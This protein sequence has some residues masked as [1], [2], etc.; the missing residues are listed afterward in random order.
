MLRVVANV[1]ACQRT[2]STRPRVHAH[3]RHGGAQTS[4]RLRQLRSSRLRRSESTKKPSRCCQSITTGE[5]SL[6]NASTISSD[7]PTRTPYVIEKWMVGIEIRRDHL[8]GVIRADSHQAVAGVQRPG[9]PEGCEPAT[10]SPPSAAAGACAL[11]RLRLHFFTSERFQYI[12]RPV[13]IN[14]NGPRPRTT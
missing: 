6:K 2:N 13:T 9:K 10:M 5:S 4:T 14:T 12:S 1:T 11:P 7:D 8:K 3:R